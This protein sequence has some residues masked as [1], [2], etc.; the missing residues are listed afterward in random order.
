ML[1]NAKCILQSGLSL[2]TYKLLLMAAARSRPRQKG[3]CLSLLSPFVKSGEVPVHFAAFG[4]KLTSSVRLSEL[5]S[6]WLSIHELGFQHIYRIE[7]AFA[8]DLIIDGGGNTGMFTLT[9]SAAFPAAKVLICEPVPANIAQI[10]K[11]LEIN[12]VNAEILPVCIGGSP[13]K[14]TFYVREANQGSFEA[15]KPYRSTLDVDVATLAELVSRSPARKILIKLDIEGMEIEALTSYLP[16]EKPSVCVIGELHDHKTN[17]AV[18]KR[19]FENNGWVVHFRD[20]SDN[21]SMF[22]AW[23]PAAVA[24]FPMAASERRSTEAA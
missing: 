17:G 5:E 12:A 9:A 8:P 2:D 22:D 19:L 4:R 13:R 3:V 10:K 21:G 11:H 1:P 7:R 15:D 16:G 18:L 20:V 14:I 23:S 24:D 6:D